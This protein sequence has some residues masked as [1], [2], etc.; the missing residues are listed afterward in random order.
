MHPSE[1]YGVHLD[2]VHAPPLPAIARNE[3]AGEER[4]TTPRLL[5]WLLLAGVAVLE[6]GYLAL[7]GSF[8]HWFVL[9][10][11]RA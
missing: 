10:M 8:A 2:E 6:L 3:A 1:R 9:R 5:H 4:E 11:I 7:L